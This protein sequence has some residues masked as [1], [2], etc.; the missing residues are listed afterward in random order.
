[1]YYAAG[2]MG[3]SLNASGQGGGGAGT[4][5]VKGPTD[6]Y[7][8]LTVSGGRSSTPTQVSPGSGA[9]YDVF[10]VS[11]SASVLLTANLSCV[12]LSITSSSQLSSPDD[13]FVLGIQT[14]DSSSSITSANDNVP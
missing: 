1:M 11:N 6:Q 13:I 4:V 9:I 5:F 12:N 7:G 10:T 8:E 3:L 2:V 14:V